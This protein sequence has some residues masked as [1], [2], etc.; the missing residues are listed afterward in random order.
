LTKLGTTGKLVLR[1]EEADGKKEMEGRRE[2]ENGIGR[3]E[4]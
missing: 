3:L 2:A 1:K 4:E